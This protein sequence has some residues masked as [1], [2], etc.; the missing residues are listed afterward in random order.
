MYSVAQALPGITWNMTG[1]WDLRAE[2][3]YFDTD[4]QL[5]S[6]NVIKRFGSATS[7]RI[8]RLENKINE[9]EKLLAASAVAAII[10]KQSECG[11][12][13]VEL[14]GVVFLKNS[15]ALT[16]ESKSAID[17][18]IDKLKV[19][20]TDIHFEVRAHTDN[21]GVKLYNYA[22]SLSRARNVRDYLAEKG[23]E[24]NRVDAQ[25]YGEWRPRDTNDTEAGRQR[26]RRAELVLLGVEKY[27]DDTGSCP[28]PTSSPVH[29]IGE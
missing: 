3:E 11:E 29:A 12:Y 1:S 8:N 22:L 6:F 25:G 27:V 24:L 20:P 28:Q 2:Y 18:I 26:N 10:K 19:L 4:A 13:S 9:Q 23:I 7:R 15:I 16:N 17:S 21:E 5:L 14:K